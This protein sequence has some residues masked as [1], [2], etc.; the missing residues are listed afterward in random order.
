MATIQIDELNTG[1]FDYEA[2]IKSYF[3]PMQ[4]TDEQKEK[5]EKASYDFRNFLLFLFAL[6]SVQKQIRSE[7]LLRARDN[8]SGPTLVISHGSVLTKTAFGKCIYLLH[9]PKI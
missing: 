6:L 2:Y 4:I 3:A 1:K 8:H 9:M 5:R 7:T